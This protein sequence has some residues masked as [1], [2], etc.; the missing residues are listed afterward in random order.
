ME[1][2]IMPFLA[3]AVPSS[4]LGPSIL[5]LSECIRAGQTLYVQRNNEALSCNHCCSGKA[6][7]IT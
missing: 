4:A 6:I 2:N 7:R 5:S 1:L 3:P